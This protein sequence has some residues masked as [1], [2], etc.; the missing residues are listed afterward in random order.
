[1]KNQQDQQLVSSLIIFAIVVMLM[2]AITGCS[3]VVPVVAKFPDAPG[4][5]AMVPCPQLEQIPGEARL[6]DITKSVVQ[7]YTTYYACAVKSDAWIEWYS[8]QKKIFEG[9]K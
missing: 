7:N 6:S 3:T 9:A 2:L 8:V 4:R 1:M 5:S